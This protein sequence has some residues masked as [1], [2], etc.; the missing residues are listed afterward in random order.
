MGGQ[1]PII[2]FI[3]EVLNVKE[4]RIYR[5]QTFDEFSEFKGLLPNRKKD[6][7]RKRRGIKAILY[8]YLLEHYIREARPQEYRTIEYSLN[9]YRFCRISPQKLVRAIKAIMLV[10]AQWRERYWWDGQFRHMMKYRRILLRAVRWYLTPDMKERGNVPDTGHIYL[11]GRMKRALK[12]IELVGKLWSLSLWW[13]GQSRLMKRYKGRL[14]SL[15]RVWIK[16]RGQIRIED[17][18]Q[19][20]KYHKVL[21]E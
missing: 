11:N 3:P 21:F 2:F 16:P 7:T 14:I 20:Y 19:F 17:V 13:P 5:Q 4:G 9:S 8:R 15:V 6:K 18:P 10:G 12:F 1:P